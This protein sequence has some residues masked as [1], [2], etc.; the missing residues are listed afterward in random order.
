[1]KATFLIIIIAPADQLQS[2][3]AEHVHCK[4]CSLSEHY[5]GCT[6]YVHITI[7]YL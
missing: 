2:M 3:F 6:T 4:C 1:M 5:Y 7:N